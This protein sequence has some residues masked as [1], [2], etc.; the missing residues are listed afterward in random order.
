ML[1]AP[2]DTI[3]SG[4]F[5]SHGSLFWLIGVEKGCLESGPLAH[6]VDGKARGPGLFW[7][8]E[9]VH[10]NL[11]VNRVKSSGRVPPLVSC[12]CPLAREGL[13]FGHLVHP[14]TA[15]TREEVIL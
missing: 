15:S 5:V 8:V 6:R 3:G 11:K 12:I 14:P 9:P 1:H 4:V 13:V 7:G 2:N 10:N